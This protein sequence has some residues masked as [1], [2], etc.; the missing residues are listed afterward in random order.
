MYFH[1]Q[2]ISRMNHSTIQDLLNE[3]FQLKLLATLNKSKNE[4]HSPAAVLN[5]PRGSACRSLR[6]TTNLFIVYVNLC[7]K[8]EKNF[9]LKY[10]ILCKVVSLSQSQKDEQLKQ[11]RKTGRLPRVRYH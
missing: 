5:I 9:T 11:Y 7:E 4:F 1:S 3:I 8:K 10:F 2:I 6:K